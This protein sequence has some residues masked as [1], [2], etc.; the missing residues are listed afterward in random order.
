MTTKTL[1]TGGLR[2]GKWGNS[3][4]VRL[5]ETISAKSGIRA[6]SPITIRVVPKGVLIEKQDRDP[7]LDE[8]IARITPENRHEY[9]W[10]DVR[11]MG[12]EIW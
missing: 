5:S 8:L 11:P 6:G 3:V 12:R 7:T 9:A 1:G 10:K 4:G 2:A